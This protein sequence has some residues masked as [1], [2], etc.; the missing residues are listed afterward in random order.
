M[1]V[2]DFAND[3]TIDFTISNVAATNTSG[4][5]IY[6]LKETPANGNGALG[7][8]LGYGAALKPGMR[9]GPSGQFQSQRDWLAAAIRAGTHFRTGG[10]W[11]N[12]TNRYLGLKFLIE[13]KVHYGWARMNVRVRGTTITATL[14]G[15]AYETIPNKAIIAGK[16]KGADVVTV[17]PASLGRLAQGSSGLAAWH[18][19][20]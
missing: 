1:C 16:T 4:T 2:L 10:P 3:K 20:K 12:V 17:Q 19:G 6:Y 14:S 18:S 5:F 9:I 7:S 13:G 8:A 11:V 15:Y